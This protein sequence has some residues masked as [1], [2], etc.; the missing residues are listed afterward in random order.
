LDELKAFELDA[1]K[2]YQVALTEVE[3]RCGLIF[4]DALKGADSVGRSLTS[5]REVLSERKPLASLKGI[6]WS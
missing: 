5:A 3:E 1:F 6:D 4:P 2:V